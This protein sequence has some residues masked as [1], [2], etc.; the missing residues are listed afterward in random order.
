MEV[1][2]DMKAID[3]KDQVESKLKD[4]ISSLN[5]KIEIAKDEIKDISHKM[6]TDNIGMRSEVEER[7]NEINERVV[8]F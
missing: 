5:T 3:L 8:E 7:V 1:S 4:A 2:V 6:H